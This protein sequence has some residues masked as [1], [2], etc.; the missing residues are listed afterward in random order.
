MSDARVRES[1]ARE[2]SGAQQ[3]AMVQAM[4]EVMVQDGQTRRETQ[5]RLRL[6]SKHPPSGRRGL[7]Q[8]R[9]W[10]HPVTV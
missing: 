9:G 8:V 2:G 10:T 3:G 7:A 6:L 1:W 5:E 4:A